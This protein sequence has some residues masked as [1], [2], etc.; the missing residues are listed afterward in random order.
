MNVDVPNQA[1]G[2]E[3]HSCEWFYQEQTFPGTVDL[4]PIR[5]PLG[6]LFGWLVPRTPSMS[7]PQV[8]SS[9]VLWGR[10]RSNEDIALIDARL[11]IW[12]P[13]RAIV[14]AAAAIVGLN[15]RSGES[16][17]FPA[18]EMQVTA[19]PALIGTVP[20]KSYRFPTAE[21][22]NPL[23]GSY[24]VE[25]NPQASLEWTS[26]GVSA[27]CRYDLRVGG[28]DGFRFH[29]DTLPMVEVRAREGLGL[30]DYVKVWATPLVQLATFF[31]GRKQE[32]TSLALLRDR[33]EHPDVDG[34]PRSRQRVKVYG[35]GLG[36]LVYKAERPDPSQPRPMYVF[37]EL[38]YDL[39]QLLERWRRLT[40]DIP[41]AL[42]PYLNTL[43][44][45]N[46]PAR[47]RFLY[48]AQTLEAIHRSLEDSTVYETHASMRD[49][50][51]K[52]TKEL[53]LEKHLR[54]FLHE[55]IDRHGGPSLRRR[56]EEL[57]EALPN[58]LREAAFAN[59]LPERVPEIR[60][61]LAHGLKDYDQDEL[62]PIDEAMK[63]VADSHLLRI[64]GLAP[65]RAF[66][67]LND[68]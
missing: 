57:I 45:D 34:R 37:A 11:E 59:S 32:I 10:L 68:N 55:R 27:F 23:E 26:S 51:L 63:L 15:L 7:F 40:T 36:Q 4:V 66:R 47:A 25:G 61:D 29:V 50:V 22:M 35:S 21:N 31:T 14:S 30:L 65:E 64:L 16:L 1:E 38:P 18:A 54:T 13:D 44:M 60:N 17:L 42:R 62:R 46:L 3:S 28:W 67:P 8:L 41:Q 53:G 39:P 56:L 9:D 20:L 24:E 33:S 12:F 2:T 43:F 6:Q 58:D 19:L 49:A 48:L 5:P 52:R